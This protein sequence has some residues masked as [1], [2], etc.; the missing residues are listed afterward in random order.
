MS[1][2]RPRPPLATPDRPGRDLSQPL[3]P[4]LS[5]IALLVFAVGIAIAYLV[6]GLAWWVPVLYGAASLVAFAAYG[7]DKSA[8]RRGA[9][10]ISEQTLLLLGLIGGWPGAIVAQ[11]LFRHKTRKRSFRRVFWGTVAVNVLLL[12]VYV[13]LVAGG[14]FGF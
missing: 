1:N 8:A 5:W 10:R 6:W 11:Q 4:A 2:A 3:P 9:A 13:Y 14:V 12:G 7:I